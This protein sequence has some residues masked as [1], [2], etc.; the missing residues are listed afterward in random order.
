MKIP[1]LESQAR[2]TTESPTQRTDPNVAGQADRALAQV[3]GVVGE[4][5]QKF[6]ELATQNEVS[7]AKIDSRRQTRDL[8]LEQEKDTDLSVENQNSYKQRLDKIKEETGKNISLPYAKNEYSQWSDDKAFIADTTIKSSFRAKQVKT[9]TVQLANT[10]NDLGYDY[11]HESREM[12]IAELDTEIAKNFS[13]GVWSTEAEKNDFRKKTIDGWNE[14]E[15]TIDL[16][17]MQN[18]DFIIDELEKGDKGIYGAVD[19]LARLKKLADAKALK[20][21]KITLAKQQDSIASQN[22]LMDIYVRATDPEG[23]GVSWNELEELSKHK[24]SQGGPLFDSSQLRVLN[25][26]KTYKAPLVLDRGTYQ[27]LK[28]QQAKVMENQDE[29]TLKDIAVYRYSIMQAVSDGKL[30]KKNATDMLKKT[31]ALFQA[32]VK[33]IELPGLNTG[34]A[35]SKFWTSRIKHTSLNQEQQDKMFMNLTNAL[36]EKI[37]SEK[38]YTNEEISKLTSDMWK[39]EMQK[40]HPEIVGSGGTP[41]HTATKDGGLKA[42]SP[43]SVDVTPTTTYKETAKKV[44]FKAKDGKTYETDEINRALIEKQKGYEI[45]G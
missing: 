37:E 15:I 30:Y 36:A 20:N 26:L 13:L 2:L 7:Q 14:K 3:A 23:Q 18:T 35:I 11:I 41:T 4:I 21:S 42:V 33:G 16:D 28:E 38:E 17:E 40:Y 25:N 9:S 12:A 45:V 8:L 10:V 34:W 39:Q 19:P 24:N 31:D 6:E 27:K 22:I 32:K 43:T 44:K 1:R 5:A 29:T